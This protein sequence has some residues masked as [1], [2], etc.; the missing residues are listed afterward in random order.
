MMR[1]FWLWKYSDLAFVG[2]YLLFVILVY[3]KCFLWSGYAGPCMF[4]SVSV[5]GCVCND[6]YVAVVVSFAGYLERY[7]EYWGGQ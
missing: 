6:I 2:L 5:I 3:R 7:G 4:W 1:R